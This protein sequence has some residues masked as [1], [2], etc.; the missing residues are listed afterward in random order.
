MSDFIFS[1]GGSLFLGLW[2]AIVAALSIL[3]FG[4]DLL[5]TGLRPRPVPQDRASSRDSIERNLH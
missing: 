4:R 2:T 1:D 3:A 5:P